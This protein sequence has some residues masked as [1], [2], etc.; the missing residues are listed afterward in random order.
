MMYL[1]KKIMLLFF[2]VPIISIIGGIWQGQFTNDGYH[3]GFIFSNALELLNGKKPFEEIFIQY[4]LGTTLIHSFV[5]FLFDKNI[6]SLV[7]FTSLIYAISLYLIGNIT[8]KLTNNF[9]YSLFSSFSIFL[10]YPWPTSPWPNFISFFFI[11][12]FYRLYISGNSKKNFISGILLGMSYFSLTIIYN[13]VILLF[14]T[15]LLILF[16]FFKKQY[17]NFIKK[18][19]YMMG[20]FFLIIFLFLIYLIYSN[21]FE[22]WFLYQK[23]PF[24]LSSHYNISLVDKFLEY[25][26]FLYIQ[27]NLNLIVFYHLLR[28]ISLLYLGFLKNL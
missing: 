20:G 15:S 27:V 6:F 22:T 24:I 3:W 2:V 11:V 17:F 14:L 4:G 7:V 13:F 21:L 26:S 25:L 9:F 8:Y 19:F 1:K 23:I 18:N 12:L 10:I 5:L 16:Y 28:L